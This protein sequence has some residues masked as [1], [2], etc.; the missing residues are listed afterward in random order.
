MC[1]R[2]WNR[3]LTYSDRNVEQSVTKSD[4]WKIV[5]SSVLESK[6]FYTIVLSPT[7]HSIT[8]RLQFWDLGGLVVSLRRNHTKGAFITIFFGTSRDTKRRHRVPRSRVSNVWCPNSCE[9][10]GVTGS[11]NSYSFQP[12]SLWVLDFLRILNIKSILLHVTMGDIKYRGRRKG[13]ENRSIQPE[14]ILS[15]RNLIYSRQF[16]HRDFTIFG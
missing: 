2:V 14:S 1:C 13:G 16:R 3:R 9:G 8:T 11:L 6:R 12:R 4:V 10:T 15:F 7:S 5:S